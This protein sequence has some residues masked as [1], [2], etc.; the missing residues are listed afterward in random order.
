MALGGE[1]T[2]P[3]SLALDE[4]IGRDGHAVDDRVGPVE[5]VGAR[6]PE[7]FGEPGERFE[8][9]G[10]LVGRGARGLGER[11]PSVPIDRDDVRERATH[12]HPDPVSS[13]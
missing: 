6:R 4:R 8:H 7:R 9:P 13:S 12:V 1:E 11:D 10:G 5:E 2:D 3:G